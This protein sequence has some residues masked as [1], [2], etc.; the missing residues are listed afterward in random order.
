[1]KLP[2]PLPML[3]AMVAHARESY[4]AEA[5]GIII[6]T[7]ERLTRLTRCRNVQDELHAED[8]AAHPR[9]TRDGYSIHPQDMFVIMKEARERGEAFRVIYHS[10]IDAGAYFSDE[11]K[12]VAIWEGEAT[13]PEAAHVVIS[14]VGGEP[15]EANIFR[16]NPGRREFDGEAV[17][18]P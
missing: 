2:I 4:P 5:C 16:W 15:K 14:V 11:D 17:A 10:H 13:Y 12:R 7:T 3:R 18:L 6:G 8:P 9:T 1:M